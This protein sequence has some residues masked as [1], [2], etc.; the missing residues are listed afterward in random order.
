MV[1]KTE[2]YRSIPPGPGERVPAVGGC[3]VLKVQ[4]HQPGEVRRAGRGGRRVE[5][6]GGGLPDVS[7]WSLVYIFWV[8][9]LLGYPATWDGPPGASRRRAFNPGLAACGQVGRA[10]A[11]GG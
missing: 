5:R 10:F 4:E 1:R 8:I 11:A 6:E 7:Q 2:E 9:L 3:F